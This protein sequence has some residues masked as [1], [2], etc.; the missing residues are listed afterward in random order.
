MGTIYHNAS[1]VVSNAV[2]NTVVEDGKVANWTQELTNAM[3]QA[4]SQ[5]IRN[6]IVIPFQNF[7]IDSWRVVI[8]LTNWGCVFGIIVGSTIYVLGDETKGKKFV[9]ISL[10][11]EL[12]V[13]MAN[14][15]FLGR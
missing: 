4:F 9:I 1:Q 15:V 8:S 2:V 7:M 5:A 10:L 6:E 13:Q 12:G 11:I 3:Q 14:W